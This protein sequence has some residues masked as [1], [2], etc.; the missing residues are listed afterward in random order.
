MVLIFFRIMLQLIQIFASLLPINI[1]VSFNRYSYLEQN[2]LLIGI[3]KRWQISVSWGAS[4]IAWQTA[5]SH[6]FPQ[7]G[8]QNISR[9][10]RLDL[11]PSK[12]RIHL[13]HP[14]ALKTKKVLLGCIIFSGIIIIYGIHYL[15]QLRYQSSKLHFFQLTQM[16]L[17]C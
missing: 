3:F 17:N 13:R 8:P 11:C 5:V 9:R 7:I 16:F 4:L 6:W 10:K 14:C 15:L 2:S 1:F 12:H